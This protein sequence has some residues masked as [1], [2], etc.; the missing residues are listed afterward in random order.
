MQELRATD[1]LRAQ[2]TGGWRESWSLSVDLAT[3]F[4]VGV[5]EFFSKSTRAQG[6]ALAPR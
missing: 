2:W 1:A 3:V 4:L 5:C 6:A